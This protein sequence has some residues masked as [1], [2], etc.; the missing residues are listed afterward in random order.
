VGDLDLEEGL[1]GTARELEWTDCLTL[2]KDHSIRDYHIKDH[3][4]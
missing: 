1:S 4:K 2:M 3:R